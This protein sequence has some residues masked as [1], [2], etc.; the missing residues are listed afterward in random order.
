M[1]S[2][3]RGAEFDSRWAKRV[4]SAFTGCLRRALPQACALCAAESGDALICAACITDMPRIA[5]A[6]PRCALASPAGIT[7]GA[8]LAKPPPQDATLAAWRYAYPADRLLHAFKYGGLLALAAPFAGAIVDAHVTR[9]DPRPNA[10]VPLPLARPRQRSRGFNQAAEIAREV[11][12]RLEV[13]TLAALARARDTPPQAGLAL[14]ARIA[15]VRNA[16]VPIASLEGLTVAIVDDVMTT[17]ATLAA[18]VRA[19]RAAGALRVSAW[20]VARTPSPAERVR[21]Q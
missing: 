17:G 1:L 2:N 16:F 21:A 11:A 3:R 9:G 5:F 15:N 19:A 20:V 12:A 14:A 7:C 6:C 13:P 8:C 18:A 4:R 10:I